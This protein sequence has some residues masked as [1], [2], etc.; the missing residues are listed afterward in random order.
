M[1]FRK[2]ILLYNLLEWVATD[3]KKWVGL[4]FTTRLVSFVDRFEK[5]VK[6]RLSAQIITLFRPSPETLLELFM[7][8]VEWLCEKE[9]YFKD[10]RKDHL[11]L[12]EKIY[13]ALRNNKKLLDVIKKNQE[14]AQKDI[15][16]S[17]N[18]MKMVFGSYESKD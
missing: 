7:R 5:R 15:V 2:Q 11:E 14:Y 17:L 1:E 16:F 9:R 12:F 3:I 13:L 6:S 18:V 8:R 4:V 10:G